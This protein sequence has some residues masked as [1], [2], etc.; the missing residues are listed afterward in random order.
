MKAVGV[1]PEKVRSV[2]AMGFTPTQ[3]ELIQMSVFK[4]D[5]PFVERMK[6]R[7]FKSLTIAQLVQIKVF[8]LD[9]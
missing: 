5:A 1:T 7:G 6:A 2:R 9:E 4:I 3:E 8:K